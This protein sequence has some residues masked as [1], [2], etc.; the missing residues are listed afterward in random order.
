MAESNRTPPDRARQ[1]IADVRV[2]ASIRMLIP[3]GKRKES[4]DILA[5]MIN[6]IQHKEGCL[7][8][9]LYRDA[10]SRQWLMYEEVWASEK[11]FRR[12]LHS[13]ELRSVLLVVEMAAEPPEI[14]FDRMVRLPGI[15]AIEDVRKGADA[16]P[17]EYQQLGY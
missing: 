5:L 4:L 14:R 13:H 2:R 7:T 10:M 16:A 6:R 17:G 3:A 8:C 1:P 11:A 12:H 9:R 15:D